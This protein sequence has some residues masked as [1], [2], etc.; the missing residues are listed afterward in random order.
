MPAAL[1]IALPLTG[2]SA[3]SI[4]GQVQVE[5]RPLE[6]AR[7]TR[8]SSLGNVPYEPAD[9]NEADERLMIR[10]YVGG[11]DHPIARSRWRF[12]SRKGDRAA[13]KRVVEFADG[14]Q[15]GR[16]Y[17]IIYT[18]EQPKVAGARLLALRNDTAFLRSGAEGVLPGA[19][20]R[21]VGFGVLQIGR[22]LRQMVRLGLTVDEGGDV[23]FDRLLVHI[24]GEIGGEFNHRFALPSQITAPRFDHLFPFAY[25]ATTDPFS[26][27]SSDLLTLPRARGDAPKVVATNT[28][29]EYWRGDAALVHL[30]R[31]GEADL[32]AKRD[33]RAY[34]FAGTQDGGGTGAQT[35]EMPLTSVSV[36]YGANVVIASA[37]LRAAFVNLDGLGPRW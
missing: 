27:Q 33:V 13:T 31:G 8:I 3:A 20:G 9:P 16:S 28:S 17:L 21:L 32:G 5:L 24:A 25:G 6:I 7:A 2:N 4:R 29:W 35:T 18:A 34:R 26:D 11:P 19:F 12:A 10:E 14:F 37:L 36:R 22:V 1:T 30:R 23:A 15:P